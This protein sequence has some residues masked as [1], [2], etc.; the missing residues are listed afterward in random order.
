MVTEGGGRVGNPRVQG[1]VFHRR[2]L[3]TWNVFKWHQ[4][5]WVS[6]RRE[7]AGRESSREEGGS[8]SHWSSTG[9]GHGWLLCFNRR[10]RGEHTD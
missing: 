4:T 1:S 2:D 9:G 8:Q 5:S 10:Q 3:E 6:R 7:T